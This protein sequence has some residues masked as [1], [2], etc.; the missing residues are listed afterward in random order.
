MFIAFSTNLMHT[1]NIRPATSKSSSWF[2][3]DYRLN[4]NIS[5]LLAELRYKWENFTSY[6]LDFVLLACF[7]EEYETIHDLL[8][9]GFCVHVN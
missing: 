6:K 1:N 2:W 7:Q 5:I 8:Y 3:P 9:L 4:V